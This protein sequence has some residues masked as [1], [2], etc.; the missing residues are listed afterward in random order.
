MI[1]TLV[2]CGL[3]NITSISVNNCKLHLFKYNF[4]CLFKCKLLCVTEITKVLT[5]LSKEK[6]GEAL[7]PWVKACTNHLYWSATST[8]GGCGKV[9]WATFSSFFG[10]IVNKHDR[11]PNQVFNKYHHLHLHYVL[12]NDEDINISPLL[13][14]RSRIFVKGAHSWGDMLF[15]HYYI[16][17]LLCSKV[18]IN[19][20][21]WIHFFS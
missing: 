17:T 2:L 5:K 13:R 6:G 11:L 12:Y 15:T 10:H 21:S 3:V 1:F 4:E 19:M 7:L 20:L 18:I 8:F 16:S 9:I 14:G